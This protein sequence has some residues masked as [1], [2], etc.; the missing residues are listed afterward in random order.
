MAIFAWLRLL[1]IVL[2]VPAFLLLLLLLLLLFVRL[3]VCDLV[4]CALELVH[5]QKSF[6]RRSH[7]EVT[8]CG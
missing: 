2:C 3:F 5:T 4:T 6:E 1:L 7:P 8:L